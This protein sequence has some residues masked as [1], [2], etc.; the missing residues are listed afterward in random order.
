MVDD[1]EHLAFQ[2]HA[3]NGFVKIRIL[4]V[5]D[6]PEKTSF[7]GGYDTF[8]TIEIKSSGFTAKV[9]LYITTRNIVD[10]YRMISKCY[11]SLEGSAYL[12]SY[13]DDFSLAVQFDNLGHARVFGEL[14][15]HLNTS[16]TL[17]FN[18]LTDQSY[19]KKTIEELRI[20]CAKYDRKNEG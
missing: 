19:L 15:E 7:L 8:S 2:I 10:F 5:F 4:E 18:L 9:N 11:D 6:F 14:S 13:E 16:N 20:I 17:K 12:K 1:G 3:E